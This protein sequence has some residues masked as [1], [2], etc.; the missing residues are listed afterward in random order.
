MKHKNVVLPVFL[1]ICIVILSA[2]NSTKA[3]VAPTAAPT[4]AATEAATVAATDVA[5]AAATEAAVVDYGGVCLGTAANAIV[6]LNCQKISIAVEN[7][8]LPFNYISVETGKAAGWDYEAW[9]IICTRLHC[10]PDFIE[11]AW[12]GMIQSV[13]DG[14]YDVGA[15][16]VTVDADRQKIVDFSIGYQKIQQ[17]LLVRKGETRFKTIED[18]VANPKLKLGTQASTTNYKTAIKYLPESRVQAFETFPFAVQALLSGDLDAIIID[19]V[20]GLGYQGTNADK[21]ELIGPSISSDELAFLYPKGSKLID[22][23]NKAVQ[24]M[25]DDGTIEK[26]QT[27]YFGPDFKITYDDI[28]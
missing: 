21:L 15:D 19:E 4:E 8:Y 13:S 23:V 1:V 14:Q 12:D 7:A 5:T 9:T 28:K 24:S 3:T 10:E 2:C 25:I 17:R 20:V 26:L 27:K 16:G 18:I 6:D 11:S 22:P